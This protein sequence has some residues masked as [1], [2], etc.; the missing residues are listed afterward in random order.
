MHANDA[1][2][3]QQP[4]QQWDAEDSRE[5]YVVRQVHDRR[6]D[7]PPVDSGNA[8]QPSTS[9]RPMLTPPCS[10][11]N[12]LLRRWLLRLLFLLLVRQHL[13]QQISQPFRL[14]CCYFFCI[15][16]L[17]FASGLLL[18]GLLVGLL[19]SSQGADN[20]SQPSLLLSR[21]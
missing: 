17:F 3:R 6:G 5:R 1:L 14:F 13:V 20:S 11:G 19:L 9:G 21:L 8:M 16:L 15:R 4:D 2:R 18:V 10:F 12:C 7:Y